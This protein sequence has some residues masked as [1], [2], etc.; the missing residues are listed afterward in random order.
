MVDVY[1]ELEFPREVGLA[2]A[3]AL[4]PGGRV[5]FVEFRKEDP[6]CRSRRSTR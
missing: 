2:L 5:A 3:A 1:H 4:K 6:R